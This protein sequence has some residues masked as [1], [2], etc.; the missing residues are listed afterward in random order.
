MPLPESSTRRLPSAPF[1]FT[2]LAFLKPSTTVVR[3]PATGLTPRIAEPADHAMVYDAARQRVVLF[4]RQGYG[5]FLDDTWEWNG[6]KWLPFAAAAHP[7]AQCD[8]AMAYY[9][10]RQ[11]TVLFG[12]NTVA[13]RAHNDTWAY[14]HLATLR[15]SGALRPGGAVNLALD[16]PGDQGRPYQLAFSLGTGPILIGGRLLGLSSDALF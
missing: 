3:L 1:H 6:A 10:A 9:P 2:A 15:V 5:V 16:A 7:L 8:H 11:C 13:V 12:G 4:G 14:R